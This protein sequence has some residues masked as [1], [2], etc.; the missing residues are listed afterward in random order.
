MLI[1]IKEIIKIAKEA[2]EA[3]LKVYEREFEVEIKDDKTPLTEADKASNEIICNSLAKLYPNIP[4]L[5]E[6]NKTIEYKDRKSWEYF[7]LI[8]PLDGTKEFIKRN[9]EFTV[10]I[11]LIYNGTPIAGVVYAPYLKLL[12]FADE[13]GAFKEEN[14]ITAKLPIIN[15]KTKNIKVVASKSHFSDETKEFIDELSRDYDEVEFTS[16]GS[17]LKLCL[18]AEGKADIYPRIAPTMEWDTGA[19]HAIVKLAGKRVI[20]YKSDEE[21]IYNKENLLN[22]YF[23]VK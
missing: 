3:I 14:H 11:A 1:D 8:D 6:E 20:Q 22:P 15:N 9:G 4:I 21:L 23:V 5:S 10:N 13:N 16:I 12:Y 7:W 19:A 2:G 17:S 18:V